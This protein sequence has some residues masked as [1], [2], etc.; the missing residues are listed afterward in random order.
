MPTAATLH[1]TSPGAGATRRSSFQILT[2]LPFSIA[3]LAR[4]QR[5]IELPSWRVIGNPADARSMSAS[6]GRFVTRLCHDAEER[7]MQGSKRDPEAIVRRLV[8]SERH[9]SASARDEV[10][11]LGAGA[12]PAL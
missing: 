12:V 1:R 8:Q 10:L 3:V 4:A 11:A 5:A 9:L 6:P 7:D 2:R